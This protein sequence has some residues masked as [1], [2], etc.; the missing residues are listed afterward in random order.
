MLGGCAY[1]IRIE[2]IPQPALVELPDQTRVTT[3]GDATVRWAP[4]D[5]QEIR[6]TATGYRPLTLDLRAK[7]VR[8]ARYIKRP[9]G[10]VR[11]EVQLI[12]VP[13]HGPTGTWSEADVPD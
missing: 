5:K 12:L 13:T 2:S 7:H 9:F 6:V 4:F 1:T 11:S 3:P 10:P 8:F